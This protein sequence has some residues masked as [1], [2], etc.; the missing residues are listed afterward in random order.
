[1]KSPMNWVTQMSKEAIS[2]IIAQLLTVDKEDPR[3]ALWR[4]DERKGVQNALKKWE[5][6]QAKLQAEQDKYQEM[7]YFE[8]KAQSK[9]YRLIAGIDE[10]GRGPLAGP[11]VAAAVILSDIQILGLNDSK[12]LS[13]KK[14]ETLYEM[15]Q[16]NAVAIGIGIVDSE[17]IDEINIYQASKK[18]MLIAVENLNPHPDFLLVDA[19]TLPIDLPQENLI[20]GDARS[21]AIAAASIIAKVTRDHLMEE[22]GKVYPHYGFERNAGY[23]TKEHLEAIEKYGILPIHRKT[24]APIKNLMT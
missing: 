13:E 20:K 6:R 12:K 11:V 19:M 2:E 5:R 23:G 24:F 10:V 3:L 16:Q 21:N 22:Y 9:G 7:A 1:M 14:R 8:E 17:E 4:Q 18:A 15:I